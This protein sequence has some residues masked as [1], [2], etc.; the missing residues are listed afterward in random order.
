MQ[1]YRKLLNSMRLQLQKGDRRL[2]RL[3]FEVAYDAHRT[4]RRNVPI[5]L[6]SSTSTS[7]NYR[8]TTTISIKGGVSAQIRKIIALRGGIA[9]MGNSIDYKNLI[10]TMLNFSGGP[11]PADFKHKDSL[12]NMN[13]TGISYYGA[14]STTSIY[15]GFCFR[16][17]RQ[18]IIDVEGWGI[19]SNKAYNDFYIDGMF[20]PVITIKDF[21]TPTVSSTSGTVTTTVDGV[22]Y[23]VK[24]GKVSHVGWRM[25]WSVRQPK[26][27]GFSLKFE[28]GVR[29]G[30]L[31]VNKSNAAVNLKN[32]YCMFTYG[33]Y[34]PLKIKPIAQ[35]E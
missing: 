3:A 6:S 34:I 29:P 1:Q 25:G 16:H 11:K 23:N 30:Y 14:Y 10:D 4:M 31:C 8:T 27:Q 12:V 35:E 9:M 7:G 28:F 26:D 17:I 32:W 19:R 2:L 13:A 21:Q 24:Y 22:K 15:G 18:L 20:A 33:L 5:V